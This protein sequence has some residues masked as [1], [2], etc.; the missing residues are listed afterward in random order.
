MQRTKK[1]KGR[2]K[3]KKAAFYSLSHACHG[4]ALCSTVVCVYSDN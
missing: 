3:A 2:K 1:K 4:A